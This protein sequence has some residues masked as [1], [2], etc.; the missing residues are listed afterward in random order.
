M[1]GSYWTSE[2]GNDTKFYITATEMYFLSRS[3]NFTEAN[4]STG[5]CIR[6]VCDN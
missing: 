5:Y 2:I 3:V 4:R 1:S 6:P